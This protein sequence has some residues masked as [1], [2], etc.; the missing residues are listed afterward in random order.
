MIDLKKEINKWLLRMVG[1]S[2]F[3]VKVLDPSLGENIVVEMVLLLLCNLC[4]NCKMD[5]SYLKEEK[6]HDYMIF[7]NFRFFFYVLL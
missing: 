6:V 1:D 7:L 4:L 3:I 2:I 5:I